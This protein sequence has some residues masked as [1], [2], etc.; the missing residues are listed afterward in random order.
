MPGSNLTKAWHISPTG[1][2]VGE[3]RDSTGRT[4]GFLLSEG[5]FTTIDPPGAILTKAH[6]I[7]PG[8]DIVGL[9]VDSSG[10]QHGFLRSLTGAN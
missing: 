3:F 2:V 8:V 1:A 9:Y 10:K 4:H 5:A 7:N 6:G